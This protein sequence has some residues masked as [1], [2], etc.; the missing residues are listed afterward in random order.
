[1]VNRLLFP[2]LFNAVEL[3][4]ETGMAAEDIDTCMTLGS[5][6]PM[7]P[8]ALLDFVGLDVSQAIG[9]SIGLK[10]PRMLRDLVAEGAVGRKAGRG[11]YGYDLTNLGDSLRLVEVRAGHFQARRTS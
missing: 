8:I 5:G 3:L 9:E 1:M 2:Y 6:V 7:G 4:A 11:F 10:V